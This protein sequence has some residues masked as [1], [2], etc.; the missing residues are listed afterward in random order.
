ML[1]GLKNNRTS[2][3]RRSADEVIVSGT[4][5][6][7]SAALRLELALETAPAELG[8]L[9]I[10]SS[11]GPVPES[12]LE[13]LPRVNSGTTSRISAS[14]LAGVTAVTGAPRTASV[15]ARPANAA[16]AANGVARRIE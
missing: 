11:T 14:A 7:S 2:A 8:K 9:L 3:W 5:N 13:V 16:L 10:W 6:L 4:W 1:L 12:T 15:I